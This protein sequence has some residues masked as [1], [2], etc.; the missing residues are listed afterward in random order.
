MDTLRTIETMKAE[1][2]IGRAREIEASGFVMYK[3][4]RVTWRPRLR[5]LVHRCSKALVT[6]NRENF[7]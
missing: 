1:M 2:V 5:L 3:G 7:L 6:R 4:D